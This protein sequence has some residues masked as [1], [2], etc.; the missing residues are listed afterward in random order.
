MYSGQ[1]LRVLLM[2]GFSFSLCEQAISAS[3]HLH[4]EPD[5]LVGNG[6][7][8]SGGG[9]LNGTV[10]FSSSIVTTNAN[11]EDSALFQT[12]DNVVR[13]WIDDASDNQSDWSST[14]QLEFTQP[15]NGIKIVPDSPQNNS[16][17]V[18]WNVRWTGS[19]N[20]ATFVNSPNRLNEYS[21][22]ENGSRLRN[23]SFNAGEGVIKI[24]NC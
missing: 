19:S 12:I 20:E 4:N 10:A 5:V 22:Y 3:I 24:W 14:F 9:M 17:S 18:V 7:G 16:D 15:I 23:G 11:N 1:S 13:T 21:L 8:A 6:T 2:V